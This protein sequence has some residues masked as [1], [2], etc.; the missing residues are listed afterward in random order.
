[1][2]DGRRHTSELQPTLGQSG[3]A[4]PSGWALTRRSA[5]T[6]PPGATASASVLPRRTASRERSERR[7]C[8]DLPGPAPTIAIARKAA[9]PRRRSV[10]TLHR[11]AVGAQFSQRDRWTASADGPDPGHLRRRHSDD[12]VSEE[13][14]AKGITPSGWLWLLPASIGLRSAASQVA[15]RAVSWAPPWRPRSGGRR[16]RNEVHLAYGEDCARLGLADPGC[17]L[18]MRAGSDDRPSQSM[19]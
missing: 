15:A 6:E 16:A 19:I 9:R 5:T 8:S 7:A 12:E 11:P 18:F 10:R 14:A 17:L 3:L 4:F 13:S 2:P 1:M